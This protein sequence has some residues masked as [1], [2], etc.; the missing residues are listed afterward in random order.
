MP[1]TTRVVI[2]DRRRE[3]GRIEEVEEKGFPP[4]PYFSYWE[5]PTSISHTAKEGGKM[6]NCGFPPSS[7]PFSI[8]LSRDSALEQ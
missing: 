8:Y 2:R 4:L 1:H 6:R 5:E 3:K 7:P